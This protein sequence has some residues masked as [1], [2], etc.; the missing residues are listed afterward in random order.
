[1]TDNSI[2]T[3]DYNKQKRELEIL[4]EE[5][6]VLHKK[7]KAFYKH[8]SSYNYIERFKKTFLILLCATL[9]MSLIIGYFLVS[10]GNSITGA[11]VLTVCMFSASVLL[12]MIVFGIRS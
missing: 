6:I 4:N 8:V 1:M 12:I 9:V 3:S 5:K 2:F 10:I 7:N 11:A